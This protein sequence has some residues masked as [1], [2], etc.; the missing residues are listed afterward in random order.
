MAILPTDLN[1]SVAPK[2]EGAS[3]TEATEMMGPDT[4]FG[5]TF[6][7]LLDSSDVNGAQTDVEGDA[8][9]INADGCEKFAPDLTD[10][11]SIKATAVPDTNSDPIMPSD[12]DF[13]TL[14]MVEVSRSASGAFHWPSNVELGPEPQPDAAYDSIAT[15]MAARVGL[16]PLTA[17]HASDKPSL[18]AADR[19]GAAVTAIGAQV[20]EM[21]VGLSEF[22]S[23]RK[24]T[25]T[26]PQQFAEEMTAQIRLLKNRSGG[27]AKLS[28]HPA[29]L[30]RMSI[31]VSTD[32]NETRIAFV[33][34]TLQA[35]QA[36]ETALPR[37]RDMLESAGLSLSDSDISEQGG[38][39]P[40]RDERGL[41]NSLAH[42]FSDDDDDVLPTNVLSLTVD[43][44]RLVDT[45]I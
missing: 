23:V 24:I 38:S 9:Q 20:E 26:E 43:P 40:E 10:D 21:A 45:Y 2:V 32:G 37:L 44:D 31:S 39:K 17:I 42:S 27:E 3:V 14:K 7:D 1:F 8:G 16:D 35:R 4:A 22:D 6:R 19:S 28:L 12:L 36:V 11:G 33:V 30:G 41:R 29:E 13:L 18:E 34:E 5:T 15:K 25:K